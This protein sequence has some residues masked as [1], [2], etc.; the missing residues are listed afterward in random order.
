MLTVTVILSLWALHCSVNLRNVLH[1]V[2]GNDS[3]EDTHFIVEYAIYG[4]S[5]EGNK[6]RR[7]HWRPVPQC[8]KIVQTWCDLSKE[9]ED[10]E[11]GYYARVRSV[12]RKTFSKWTLT[13]RRFDPKSETSFGPPLVTVEIKNN[14]AIIT[15]TGPMRHLPT[16]NTTLLSMQ[17]IY[18]QM[19]YNLSINNTNRNQ[20]HHFLV[21]SS[22]FKYHLTDHSTQYCFSARS[23]FLNMPVECHSSAWQC[24]TTPPD[25]VVEHLK[26]VIVGIA[27]PALFLCVIVVVCYILYQYLT[28]NG[29]KSPYT[30][31]EMDKK[32]PLFHS[33]PITKNPD[34]M[35]HIQIHPKDVSPSDHLRL[36]GQRRI[37]GPPP[38]YSPQ[39]FGSP[40]NPGELVDE[41]D[42]GFVSQPCK[43]SSDGEKEEDKRLG[44]GNRFPRED[45]GVGNDRS[46]SDQG[47]SYLTQTSC[48]AMPTGTQIMSSPLWQACGWSVLNTDTPTLSQSQLEPFQQTAESM[49]E[50]KE[51]LQTDP[52][53]GNQAKK[54]IEMG[55]KTCVREK[56]V[57]HDERE[58]G[59][60]EF[61]N[62][63]LLC[64]YASQIQ[65]RSNS[66]VLPNEYGLLIPHATHE[67]DFDDEEE[68]T[69]CV[70]WDPET[71]KFMVPMLEMGS[72][73][74]GGLETNRGDGLSGGNPLHMNHGG[75]RLENVFV[76]QQSEEEAETQRELDRSRETGCEVEN[77][78]KK[79]QL[80]IADNE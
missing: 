6:G 38:S 10:E 28:G 20:M 51:S 79:W 47:A 9:T 57:N 70:D 11:Q 80:V 12:H 46:A 74:I 77:V 29:Q 13:Q 22:P 67:E 78:L 2:Q 25:P 40:L 52:F 48:H 30:L 21:V 69:T 75:L 58:N 14:S 61:E 59:D 73:V 55:E 54:K 5:T 45:G 76:R 35:N 43:R 17:T 7:V 31:A 66:E 18:P 64:A 63:P 42:Y 53:N 3:S 41:I 26:K 56:D 32:P 36:Q 4:D 16:K 1:W 34:T 49:R 8:T 27:V 65:H 15:M 71:G 60:G 72:G 33:P 50:N 44:K 24:I 23:K 68:G 19:T 62:A 37:E 39:I